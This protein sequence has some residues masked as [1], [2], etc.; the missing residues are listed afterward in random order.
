MSAYR[1]P[2]FSRRVALSRTSV[3]SLRALPLAIF[4]PPVLLLPFAFDEGPD[5]TVMFRPSISNWEVTFILA[6]ILLVTI[7]LM[8]AV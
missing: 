8:L 5:A 6:L 7:D 2:A 4:F 1:W 3:P